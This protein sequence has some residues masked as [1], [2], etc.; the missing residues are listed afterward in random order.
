MML[1]WFQGPQRVPRK[2]H[3]LHYCA[4]SHVSTWC[5]IQPHAFQLEYVRANTWPPLAACALYLFLSPLMALPHPTSLSFS[6]SMLRGQLTCCSWRY[7][8]IQQKL[9][10][11]TAFSFPAPHCLLVKQSLYCLF[12]KLIFKLIL[13]LWLSGIHCTRFFPFQA[14][15]LVMPEFFGSS[16]SLIVHPAACGIQGVTRGLLRPPTDQQS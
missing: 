2:Y 8:E 14:D 9:R 15:P 16:F 7:T 10:E 5:K 11:D 3:P 12:V 6:T 1:S 13:I 4:P